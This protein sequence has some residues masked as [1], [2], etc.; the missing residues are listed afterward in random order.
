[1]RIVRMKAWYL[2]GQ[3]AAYAHA[4]TCTVAESPVEAL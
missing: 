1:M 3:V 4:A 2:R